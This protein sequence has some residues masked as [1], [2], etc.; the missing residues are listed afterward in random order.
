MEPQEKAPPN[1]QCKDSFL[2]Q[3]VFV[4]PKATIKDITL[5]TFEKNSGY[6]VK[7]LIMPVVYVAPPKPPS[8]SSHKNY[9]R[10]EI[11]EL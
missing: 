6:E 2:F 4:R 7:E 10:S 9:L 1:M 11:N 8:L 3:T 5:E